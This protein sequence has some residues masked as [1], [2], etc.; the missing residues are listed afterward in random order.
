MPQKADARILGNT[1]V[2]IKA[3]ILTQ[4]DVVNAELAISDM[5]IGSKSVK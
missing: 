5:D 3:S 1:G 4:I 2:V